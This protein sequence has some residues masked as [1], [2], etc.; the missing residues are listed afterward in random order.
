MDNDGSYQHSPIVKGGQGRPDEDLSEF[1]EVVCAACKW[2]VI[3][4]ALAAL[5]WVIMGLA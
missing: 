3:V 4:A 1:G 5:A 2:C